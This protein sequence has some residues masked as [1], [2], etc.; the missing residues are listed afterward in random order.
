MA[1]SEKKESAPRKPILVIPLKKG[2]Y[3]RVEVHV[4][5]HGS[6][7]GIRDEPDG[8]LRAVRY[9]GIRPESFMSAINDVVMGERMGKDR[10]DDYDASFKSFLELYNSH[11]KFMENVL[12]G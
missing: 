3:P 2:Y 1:E 8:T 4:D 6:S 10:K 9:A 11:K 12:E 7:V 5:S